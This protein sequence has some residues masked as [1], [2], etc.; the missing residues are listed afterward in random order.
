LFF[1]YG[2]FKHHNVMV[3]DGHISGLLDWECAGDY[4]QFTAALRFGQKE[5]WWNVMVMRLG[6]DRY[7]AELVGE[8]ALVSLTV[9][10]WV[11]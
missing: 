10:S 2:E 11:W 1:T 9:D 6:S 3:L 8:R 5:F 7:A 4:L